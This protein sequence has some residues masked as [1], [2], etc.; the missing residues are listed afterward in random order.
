MKKLLPIGLAFSLTVGATSFSITSMQ[1][2]NLI[3]LKVSY[4]QGKGIPD[5][6][7]GKFLTESIKQKSGRCFSR[8]AKKSILRLTQVN[9][10]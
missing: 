2:H 3:K 6:V 4:D 8:R 9:L 1:Q 7:T 10:A 5:F